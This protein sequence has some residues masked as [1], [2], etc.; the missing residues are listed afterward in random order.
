MSDE[1][2]FLTT[3]CVLGSYLLSVGGHSI[4]GKTRKLNNDALY[5]GE[6]LLVVADGAGKGENA[7]IAARTAVAV[8]QD[9]GE[10]KSRDRY[11]TRLDEVVQEANRVVYETAQRSEIHMATTCTALR[12]YGCEGKVVWELAHVGDSRA[13]RANFIRREY[14]KV[15]IDHANNGQLIRAVGRYRDVD[16]EYQ[17]GTLEHEDFFILCSDG[18]GKAINEHDVVGFIADILRNRK[19]PETAATKTNKLALAINDC[20]NCTTAVLY[21]E[22]LTK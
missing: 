21:V 5:C 11:T 4:K 17:E 15:T 7:G 18:V 14:R 20:D 6:G 8:V 9:H 22:S 10:R 19:G 2:T 3:Q 13:Y 12:W 16:V 1:I